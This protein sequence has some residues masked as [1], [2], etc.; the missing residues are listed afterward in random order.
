MTELR[1]YDNS[2]EGF[3]LL[4]TYGL[5]GGCG[6]SETATTGARKSDGALIDPGTSIYLFQHGYK[7]FGGDYYRAQRLERLFDHWRTLV[8]DGVWSV[9]TDGV[10]GTIETFKDAD[11]TRWRDYV[12]PPTW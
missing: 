6:D 1:V 3:R 8:V 12:I 9:E 4:L 5:E 11:S 2:E 7:P 10:E